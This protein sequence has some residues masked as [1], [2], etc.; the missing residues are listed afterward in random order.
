MQSSKWY[1]LSGEQ[2]D[3]VISTR[4][5]LARNLAQY[6]FPAYLTPAQQKQVN[7]VII[8]AFNDIDADDTLRFI[9]MEMVDQTTAV[10]MAEKRITSPEFSLNRAGKSLIVT[11]DDSVSIMLG[12]EDHIR[13]QVMKAGL[14]LENTFKIANEIDDRLSEKLTFA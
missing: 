8:N 1:S 7:T 5:R 12:E 14:D 11:D 6:P 10:A 3:I 2:D 4:I 9:D 13:L